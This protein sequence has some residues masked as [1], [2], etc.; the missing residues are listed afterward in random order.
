MEERNLASPLGEGGRGE[1]EGKEESHTPKRKK[2]PGSHDNDDREGFVVI[3]TSEAAPESGGA[4]EP[5]TTPTTATLATPT[6]IS[7]QES[8]KIRGGLPSLL[9]SLAAAKQDTPPSPEGENR[10]ETEQTKDGQPEYIR[11]GQESSGSVSIAGTWEDPQP[12]MVVDDEVVVLATAESEEPSVQVSSP[13]SMGRPNSNRDDMVS[14]PGTVVISGMWED[15]QPRMVI[16]DKIV[17]MTTEEPLTVPAKPPPPMTSDLTRNAK[18]ETHSV[19]LTPALP[20]QKSSG[21]QLPGKVLSGQLVNK[22]QKYKSDEISDLELQRE[23][24]EIGRERESKEREAKKER[25]WREGERERRD[26]QASKEKERRENER[27][28]KDRWNRGKRERENKTSHV[29]LPVMNGDQGEVPVKPLRRKTKK[30]T[31]LESGENLPEQVELVRGS[32][33]VFNCYFF[34]LLAIVIHFILYQLYLLV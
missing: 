14:L 32:M 13:T 16:D 22:D 29:G 34:L 23:K 30:F 18:V 6:D 12:R 31:A 10:A 4:K 3:G 25:E 8:A 26:E 2:V 9:K 15:P 28:K 5:E 27:E 11:D 7:R 33:T 20:E 24:R 17:T 21:K 1:E 19:A